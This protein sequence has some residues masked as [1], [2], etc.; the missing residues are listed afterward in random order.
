MTE[1]LIIYDKTGSELLNIDIPENTL[2]SWGLMS[3]EYVK[4]RFVLS[5][6]KYFKRGS[7]IIIGEGRF[8]LTE[9]YKPRYDKNT[10]CYSYDIQFDAWYYSLN[11]RILTF[12]PEIGSTETSFT[13]TGYINN[14]IGIFIKNL[15]VYNLNISSGNPPCTYNEFMYGGMAEELHYYADEESYKQMLEDNDCREVG[16]VVSINE[17]KEG[18]VHDKEVKCI[19]YDNIKLF[20]FFNHICG[21]D[22]YNCE[23][24]VD[25]DVIHIGHLENDGSATW[26]LDEQCSDMQHADSKTEYASRIIAF[27]STRN[28]PKRYRRDLLFNYEESGGH[29]DASRKMKAEWFL[30]DCRH[31]SSMKI[32]GIEKQ[33]LSEA[34]AETNE[35]PIDD[36]PQFSLK[37]VQM[38]VDVPYIAYDPTRNKVYEFYDNNTTD[39]ISEFFRKTK[40]QLVME[41]EYQEELVENVQELGFTFAAE[42]HDSTGARYKL[43]IAPYKGEASANTK[44]M[45]IRITVPGN[46]SGIVHD[47][48]GFESYVPYFVQV[49][50][51]RLHLG[52]SVYSYSLDYSKDNFYYVDTTLRIPDTEYN[53]GVTEYN[54]YIGKEYDVRFN[55][56][57][58]T[59]VTTS[60]E[61]G[62]M[63]FTEN[64]EKIVMSL[65]EGIM[66][67]LDNVITGKVPLR[68]FTDKRA[69][70]INVYER[71]LML[72]LD[73][74]PENYIDSEYNIKDGVVDED[75]IVEIVKVYDDIYPNAKIKIDKV[76]S[77]IKDAPDPDD[78]ENP[79][80]LIEEEH[81]RFF[82]SK[83]QFDFSEDYLTEDKLKVQFLE[84]PM[85]GMS[86][87]V[88]YLGEGY[89]DNNED[90]LCYEIEPNTDYGIQIPSGFFLP[91]EG[92]QITFWG[93]DPSQLSTESG[94]MVIDAENRLLERAR[95]TMR[96]IEKDHSRYTCTLFP[97]YAKEK[98][99]SFF[100]KGMKV[101]LVNEGLFDEDFQSR[102]EGIEYNVDMDYLDPKFIVGE[103][104]NFSRSAETAKSLESVTVKLDLMARQSEGSMSEFQIR[105]IVKRESGKRYL[106]RE[107]NDIA[108]GRI[109]FKKGL[110]SFGNTSFGAF[111]KGLTGGNINPEGDGEL[112]R[113]VL[114]EELTVPKLNYN[115]VI[116]TNGGTW[117]AQGGGTIETVKPDYTLVQKTDK[118]GN[119]LVDENGNPVYRKGSILNTGVLTLH[120][121]DGE[122]PALEVG[123][124]CMGLYH[125]MDTTKND[126][127][128]IDNRNGEIRMSGFATVYFMIT[129]KI[130][131]NKFRYILRQEDERY[132][133]LADT[134][135]PEDD[136]SDE[137]PEDNPSEET[138]EDNTNEIPEPEEAQPRMLRMA[139]PRTSP[140]LG[141][142]ICEQT[143]PV[144]RLGEGNEVGIISKNTQAVLTAR[145]IV[146]RFWAL[147]FSLRAY[148]NDVLYPDN[149]QSITC[150][151]D[152][153]LYD[154]NLT[155]GHFYILLKPGYDL[156][157]GIEC[158]VTATVNGFTFIQHV[159]VC[160][161]SMNEALPNDMYFSFGSAPAA[162]RK[163]A[164]GTFVPDTVSVERAAYSKDNDDDYLSYRPLDDS[165]GAIVYKIG[166]SEEWIPY[167]G[168]I[169]SDTIEDSI[170][171]RWVKSIRYPGDPDPEIPDVPDNPGEDTPSGGD[172]PEDTTPKND[173]DIDLDGVHSAL[174]DPEDILNYCKRFYLSGKGEKYLGRFPYDGDKHP[175]PQMEFAAYSNSIEA[176]RQ[177]SQFENNQYKVMLSGM[178]DWL[179]ASS[180]IRYV[181]G[182]LDGFSIDIVKGYDEN[183]KPII[184]IMPLEGYGIGVGN[185]YKWGNEMS[186]ER[187]K[188][189]ISQQLYYMN[190]EDGPEIVLE[191]DE[192]GDFV[193]VVDGEPVPLDDMEEE[194]PEDNEENPEEEAPSINYIKKWLQSKYHWTTEPLSPS[195][196]KQYV[197]GFWR[198]TY[199]EG[200][201]TK[202]EDS[203]AFL[204]STF[205]SMGESALSVRWDTTVVP[206]KMIT[207]GWV[208]DD[209][210]EEVTMAE[211]PQGAE[212][213]A[214]VLYGMNESR[215][216][217]DIILKD[218][219]YISNFHHEPSDGRERITFDIIGFAS[220]QSVPLPFTVV[221]EEGDIE[222]SVTLSPVLD[223]AEGFSG[224]DGNDG[225]DA[226][227]YEIDSSV[228]NIVYDTERD[229]FVNEKIVFSFFKTIG[230]GQRM[231]Y[232][233]R[234][235]VFFIN[236][237]GEVIGGTSVSSDVSVEVTL[238]NPD[239]HYVRCNMI[240]IGST[241]L[242]SL[243]LQ[244]VDSNQP[245]PQGPKGDD[246]DNAVM[247][248]MEPLQDAVHTNSSGMAT[249]SFGA[250]LYIIN[251]GDR[252]V[253]EMA[254]WQITVNKPGGHGRTEIREGGSFTMTSSEIGMVQSLVVSVY[255]YSTEEKELIMTKVF[256]PVADGAKGLNGAVVRPRGQWD[257]EEDYV[258]QSLLA[259]DGIRYVDVVYYLGKMYEC[260]PTGDK[261]VNR[262]HEPTETAYWTQADTYK[263]IATDLLMAENAFI[264][265]LSG[266]GI[267]LK[268]KNGD[269]AIGL[270]G[271]AEGDIPMIFSGAKENEPT[272]APFQV[273]KDG[274]LISANINASFQNLTGL[275]SGRSA[276]GDGY[277]DLNDIR[278]GKELSDAA[279][280]KHRIKARVYNIIA[281][282]ATIILP[283]DASFIGQRTIICNNET[284]INEWTEGTNVTQASDK[285]FLGAGVWSEKWGT[286]DPSG[287]QSFRSEFVM[288]KQIAFAMG[289]ME[290]VAIPDPTDPSGCQWSL[291]TDGTCAKWYIN[292]DK[293]YKM[294]N[295]N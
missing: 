42:S 21:E 145:G 177:F 236:G 181:E 200:S 212:L 174:T 99:I 55:D 262:G 170:T 135:A 280:N 3:H 253:Y 198:V 243:T 187:P 67:T 40:V 108:S 263:F 81:F 232:K 152:P 116:Y 36:I 286:P 234:N 146:S 189:L 270:Q 260:K 264:N 161:V 71:R 132:R 291:I 217:L 38:L 12:R 85:A 35:L 105:D 160:S 75:N 276:V 148:V 235:A 195:L 115:R 76:V 96:K 54:A 240:G 294:T 173:D 273:F 211:E 208:E 58:N 103:G 216:I 179:Y 203:D 6:P 271:E 186:L 98:G 136:S 51:N 121:E 63:V 50:D 247:F 143:I 178:T 134:F 172:T 293:V 29:P 157:R 239:I 48:E 122:Y 106:S 33:G 282:H 113:L 61:S 233:T 82:V 192:N 15:R 142:V 206:V 207:S 26:E 92:E 230:N 147:T 57:D 248:V 228:G 119:P 7:Y 214:E 164:D 141:S 159:T 241:T 284:G 19:T 267:Y 79:D 73:E 193:L 256:Y 87:D 258:N 149:F 251:G 16:I 169:P 1:K 249:S 138:P 10:G 65:P 25:G 126:T 53:R 155:D 275:V 194:T 124:K 150:D 34:V 77:Y 197:Y 14:H 215:T 287:A 30:K 68:Y 127:E 222:T 27:G 74:C 246:G 70:S 111:N 283:N 144:Y 269:V 254:E 17:D 44:K 255:D 90:N 227:V 52:S 41:E 11:R 4:T 8:V 162:I 292:D 261:E 226:V 130:E 266:Q 245:G 252:S 201:S 279:G 78:P 5:K 125:F 167:E 18:Y 133:Q 72:P 238:D 219:T 89:D 199:L 259:I 191:K 205:G 95:M 218:N 188:T 28:V 288:V 137:T 268:D 158:D 112:R 209:E 229:M 202:V 45:Y 104:L 23:W 257:P 20:D 154:V 278:D 225:R 221:T 185:I 2:Y 66:Y 9:D 62:T 24:W 196:E 183:K 59:R 123:D 97:S 171:F 182:Y 91:S 118:D 213:Y 47:I 83:N 31:V 94:N 223:G 84:G 128:T 114:R 153:S 64:G 46:I 168:E 272:M 88:L 242:K 140:I 86:F 163:K 37:N 80:S 100:R 139:A 22:H 180:N 101:T 231:P 102:I 265:F 166:D 190:T 204:F 295:Y 165:V 151:L 250:T 244:R 107:D 129:E 32:I 289:T 281:N 290:F 184:E 39:K 285:Y 117:R 56:K 93:Y 49:N 277:I 175:Q 60:F 176:D 69:S 120:L 110:I 224:M 220:G 237:D 131:D 43:S 156:S 274:S 13:L 210:P 109:Q